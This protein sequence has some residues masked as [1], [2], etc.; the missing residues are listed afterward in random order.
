MGPFGFPAVAAAA[1]LIC[2]CGSEEGPEPDLS[3]PAVVETEPAAGAVGVPS[4]ARIRVWFDEA[5]DNTRIV[6]DDHLHLVLDGSN[7]YG[8]GSYDLEQHVATLAL[9]FDLAPGRTYQTVLLRG[10]CDMAGNCTTGPYTWSF[11]VGQ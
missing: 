3:P 7:W 9:A 11:T 2:G 5:V 6:W 4:D 1:L 8:N 10:V